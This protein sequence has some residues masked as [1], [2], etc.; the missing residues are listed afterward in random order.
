MFTTQNGC[1][2]TVSNNQRPRTNETS[3]KSTMKL[4]SQNGVLYST[5]TDEHNYT[6][7]QEGISQTRYERKTQQMLYT[8]PFTQ[9]TESTELIYT[10]EVRYGQAL[11]LDLGANDTCV[12]SLRIQ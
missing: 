2:S 7:N 12:F 3:I 1:S 4:Y 11:S 6:Q 8:V 9:N 10:V 5:E